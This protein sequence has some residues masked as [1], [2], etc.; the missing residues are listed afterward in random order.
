MIAALVN[1][2]PEGEGGVAAVHH[3]THA[4]NG[5][6]RAAWGRATSCRLLLQA[7][8]VG[9][10]WGAVYPQAVNP[11][12]GWW[13]HWW[14][15][16]WRGGGCERGVVGTAKAA[17]VYRTVL[18][19]RWGRVRGVSAMSGKQGTVFPLLARTETTADASTAISTAL[20][21]RVT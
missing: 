9:P 7:Q 21:D 5:L 12:V 6:S 16:R 20:D 1:K 8:R 11:A 18:L 17:R 10:A 14:R 13:Q 15:W 2:W 19:K 3:Y 4:F